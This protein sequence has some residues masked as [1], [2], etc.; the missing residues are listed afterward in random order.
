MDNGRENLSEY[1]PYP[2]TAVSK[3]FVRRVRYDKI[4]SL[5]GGVTNK[6]LNHC[7]NFNSLS[8][9]NSATRLLSFIGRQL[10]FLVKQ[11]EPSIVILAIF[12]HGKSIFGK[13][14][15]THSNISSRII[16]SYIDSFD[17]NSSEISKF[18][19]IPLRQI[20]NCAVSSMS[21]L[22]SNARENS[23]NK[24]YAFSAEATLLYKMTFSIFSVFWTDFIYYIEPALFDKLTIKELFAVLSDVVGDYKAGMINASFLNTEFDQLSKKVLGDCVS[25]LSTATCRMFPSPAVGSRCS[26]PT[27]RDTGLNGSGQLCVFVV[28]ASFLNTEFDQLSKKVLGDCVSMLSTATCQYMFKNSSRAG[29]NIVAGRMFP[30]PAVGSRCSSPTFRDTGLNGSGQLCVFV[31]I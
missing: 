20:R 18:P 11:G 25:M 23:R 27:F 28:N 17:S 9:S 19:E 22:S 7:I 4:E 12:W 31:G 15:S 30:S 1:S 8:E 14:L 2:K 3:Q 21:A 5:V 10:F 26:S 6:C 13:A 24:G 29:Q 16:V